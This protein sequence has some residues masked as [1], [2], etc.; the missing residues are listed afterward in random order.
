MSCFALSR[1]PD[2]WSVIHSLHIIEVGQCSD[3]VQVIS[4]LEGRREGG[5]EGGEA[6]EKREGEGREGDRKKETHLFYHAFR[7]VLHKVVQQSQSLE[8]CTPIAAWLVERAPN[9][10][11]DLVVPEEGG[12]EG[13]KEGMMVSM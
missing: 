3:L 9:R 7:P 11:H 4:Y 6:L 8:H 12:K 5:R 1:T 13:G 10:L 2:P